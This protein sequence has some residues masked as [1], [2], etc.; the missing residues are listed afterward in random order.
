MKK[1]DLRKFRRQQINL[2]DLDDRTL[3]LNLYLTQFIVL[4]IGV[5]ILWF[6]KPNLSAILSLELGPQILLWG[7]G[8]AGLAILVDLGISRIVPE[9]ITDDGGMNRRLFRS[10]P[11]WHIIMICLVVSF[12]EE[13]LFRAAIGSAIGPYWTSILFALIH[14]RYLHHWLLTGLVFCISYGL[15]WMYEET[16]TLWVPVVAHFTIDLVM[17]C[18]IKYSKEEDS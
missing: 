8:F 5:I 4:V 13:V 14:V 10:R 3:L 11:L 16:G 12:C 9:Q 18:L 2:E 15:G 7:V 17:G 6:Q 1:P